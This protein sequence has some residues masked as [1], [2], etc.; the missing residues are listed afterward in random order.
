ME[1][2]REMKANPSVV[3]VVMNDRLPLDVRPILLDNDRLVAW[4]MFTDDCGSIVVMVAV[5]IMTSTD[6][7]TSADR[8]N[9]NI[10]A[11]LICE[12]RCI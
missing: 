3:V 8:P 10:N 11:N 9:A 6:C 5:M 7:D 1:M 12:Y 2:A 4:L